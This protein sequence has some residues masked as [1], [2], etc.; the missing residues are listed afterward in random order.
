MNKEKIVL[1]FMYF[2]RLETTLAQKEEISTGGASKTMSERKSYFRNM[3]GCQQD[4]DKK[5]CEREARQKEC[6]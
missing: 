1:N 3:E 4:Q 6:E 2:M 5:Q